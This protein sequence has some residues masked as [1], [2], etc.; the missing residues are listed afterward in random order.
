MRKFYIIPLFVIFLFFLISY[1]YANN[2]IVYL[3][4]NK[5]IIEKNEE[6]EI[7]MNLENTKTAAYTVYLYFDNEKL[8][9]ISGP[10]NTNVI[11]NRIIHVWYDETGGYFPK[12]GE[13]AKFVFKSKEEGNS[14]I[15]IKG[16]FYDS[17]GDELNIKFKEY[18]IQIGNKINSQNLISKSEENRI[19][20][21]INKN[22]EINILNLNSKNDENT[23]LE[24]LSIEDTLLYPYF[25]TNVTSYNVSVPYNVEKLKI[26]AIPEIENAKVRIEGNNNL[27]EGENYIKVVVTSENGI[28]EKVYEIKAYKRNYEE[29][30]NYNNEQIINEEKL[31]ELYNSLN[32]TGTNKKNQTINQ[33]DYEINNEQSFNKEKSNLSD[34]N[35]ENNSDI[36][37]INN[38]Y[39]NTSNNTIVSN[40]INYNNIKSTDKVENKEEINKKN[41]LKKI[42]I[43]II[44]FI[45]LNIILLIVIITYIYKKEKL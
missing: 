1:C 42:T 36:I 37:N 6:V 18:Q 27:L 4:C 39:E 19:L 38:N 31:Q 13:I 22:D 45:L 30:N 3:N 14:I 20:N 23:N 7:I 21:M 10:D 32:D 41:N 28:F 5:S 16:E 8:D 9:Y 15:N 43:K 25:D 17:N 35:Q 26:L 34:Y 29:E 12:D 2:G 24:I 33:M 11:K 40:N 44:I